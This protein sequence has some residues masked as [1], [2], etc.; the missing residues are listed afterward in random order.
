MKDLKASDVMVRPVVA[1]KK[2]AQARDVAL[3]LLDGLYSGMPV[4]DDND[5]VIG[6]VSELDILDAV[7]KEKQL[8]KITAGEIMTPNPVTADVA[9][10]LADIVKLMKKKNIIRLP[11]TAEGKLVG[12]VARCD[13][14]KT[15]IEPEFV[16]YM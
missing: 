4:T 12:V 15:L 3:Q 7:L 10:P 5:A 8:E 13:I 6:V 16:T 2:N 1:A 9:T 14:L 11:I